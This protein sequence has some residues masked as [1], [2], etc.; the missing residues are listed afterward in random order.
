MFVLLMYV[1]SCSYAHLETIKVPVKK[2]NAKI[3]FICSQWQMSHRNW[4]FDWLI[5]SPY[6]RCLTRG[7]SSLRSGA[8]ACFDFLIACVMDIH[9][10]IWIPLPCPMCWTEYAGILLWP[11]IWWRST[12]P[13]WRE[14]GNLDLFVWRQSFSSI[15]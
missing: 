13:L 4:N 12:F 9:I 11:Q 7:D 15:Q 1:I 3:F 8:P 6:S 5:N 14:R 2:A 10:S